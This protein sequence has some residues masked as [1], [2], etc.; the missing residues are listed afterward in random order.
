M[1][2]TISFSRYKEATYKNLASV[3]SKVDSLQK[4]Q[5]VFSSI[6]KEAFIC[7]K[8]AGIGIAA[9]DI[10]G[11]SGIVYSISQYL[12]PSSIGSY[13]YS[14]SVKDAQSFI[15]QGLQLYVPV[16]EEL[17]N[18][19]L[20]QSI[21]LKHIPKLVLKK[22][23]FGKIHLLDGTIAKITRI[24]LSAGFFGILHLGNR[25]MI[26]DT[27]LYSQIID[28][29]ISGLLYGLFFEIF[30]EKQAFY[31]CVAGHMFKNIKAFS[32]AHQTVFAH[33]EHVAMVNRITES[34]LNKLT[35]L[36]PKF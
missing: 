27:R 1:S 15:K 23:G 6:G 10:L 7:A 29:T 36:T 28:A 35:D 22:I 16:V 24:T 13:S 5:N 20:V 3:K 31:A 32:Y 25:G 33:K 2:I 9:E 26:T 18:R 12:A 8:Y 14:E 21:L 34:L 30:P 19:L 4:I 17:I 11:L